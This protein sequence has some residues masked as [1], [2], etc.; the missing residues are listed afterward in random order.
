VRGSSSFLS[1]RRVRAAWARFT[2]CFPVVLVSFVA[3]LPTLYPRHSYFLLLFCFCCSCSHST[4]FDAVRFGSIHIHTPLS[5]T[6]LA[7]RDE[8][9][10]S[11]FSSHCSL[12]VSVLSCL[13]LWLCTCLCLRLRLRRRLVRFFLSFFSFFSLFSLATRCTARWLVVCLRCVA[14]FSVRWGTMVE[15]WE[16]ECNIYVCL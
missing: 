11:R 6:S 8:I 3:S 10:L 1:S 15:G 2:T 7:F 4:P 5:S 9:Y 13:H 16:E 12:H 14:L